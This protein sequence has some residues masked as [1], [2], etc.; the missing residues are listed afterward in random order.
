MSYP[1]VRKPRALG[2][3]H[4]KTVVSVGCREPSS[5]RLWQSARHAPRA[6]RP[7]RRAR[8]I[9]PVV[10]RRPPRSEHRQPLLG[11]AAARRIA[12]P[13]LYP[14]TRRR[15]R[16]RGGAA[17][18]LRR[19]RLPA[20]RPVRVPGAGPLPSARPGAPRGSPRF[21]ARHL[22][23]PASTWATRVR[24]VRGGGHQARGG[25]LERS[26]ST[27]RALLR[28]KTSSGRARA[29]RG[30]ERDAPA[31]RRRAA[32]RR[33]ACAA[34]AAS[35][36]WESRQGGAASLEFAQKQLQELGTRDSAR[37]RETRTELVRERERG[38]H[39]R[40][41]A[42]R[43]AEDAFHRLRQG[44][45]GRGRKGCRARARRRAAPRAAP[46]SARRARARRSRAW[47]RSS[48]APATKIA[49]CAWRARR[50]T[51]T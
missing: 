34:E 8:A 17:P 32:F 20:R 48:A 36:L 13:G 1:R 43:R 23:P 42:A 26:T 7:G 33:S 45:R 30:G 46:R 12:N 4:W 49:S 2:Q 14:A 47:K 37:L 31:S 29:D 11:A 10:A 5:A 3:S 9:V 51:A 28:R 16:C 35:A 27:R 44:A 24:R 21:R 6:L 18:A 38:A 40:E 41:R 39:P 15:S 25:G 50:S 22:R 19:A